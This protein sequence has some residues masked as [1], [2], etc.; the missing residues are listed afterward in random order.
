[1][2]DITAA[3]SG[4]PVLAL[5]LSYAAGVAT[6]FTPCVY[7]LIPITVGIIGGNTPKKLKAFLLSLLYVLGMSVTYT[8][9][10]IAA[11]LG[12]RVF[13]LTAYNPWVNLL[14]GT[15]LLVLGLSMT[16]IIY[17]PFTGGFKLD[18]SRFMN[19]GWKGIFII[20]LISGLVTAPCTT[21]VL[22]TIL[23][24]VAV[25]KNVMMGGLHL[26]V[27]GFGCGTLLIV[28]GTFSGIASGLPK[29]GKWME[30]VKKIFGI[31]IILAALYFYY[32]TIKSF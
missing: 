26:F 25:G 24:F 1:M 23:S 31:V 16:G 32:R 29:S 21:P 11:S 6:S 2:T 10:G 17:I 9:L 28:V 3:L 15:V 22:G 20:G 18:A 5:W 7:P 30:T 8:V 13:G 19:I 27:Y 4:N 14:V 12:G